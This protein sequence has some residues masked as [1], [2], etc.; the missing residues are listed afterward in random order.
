MAN[1]V[2]Q[3]SAPLTLQT[4]TASSLQNKFQHRLVYPIGLDKISAPGEQRSA[5]IPFAMFLPYYRAGLDT[6]VSTGPKTVLDKIP[7]PQF[8]IALPLPTS[9][10]RTGY[11]VTYDTVE[12]GEF[13]MIT[14]GVKSIINQVSETRSQR[15]LR[16]EKNETGVVVPE[17][18]IGDFISPTW[19]VIKKGVGTS[20]GVVALNVALGVAGSFHEGLGGA[21]NKTLGVQKNP[22]TEVLFKNVGFRTHT[23][24]YRFLPKSLEES[25]L[26]DQIIQTFRYYMLPAYLRLSSLGDVA[27]FFSFP[28]E[29][30]IVSSQSATT[31]SMLPSVLESLNVDYGGTADSPKFFV[32]DKR[33]QQYPTQITLE[34]TFKEIIILTRDI[35]TAETSSIEQ[36]QNNVSGLDTL[37]SMFGDAVR[38]PSAERY[39]F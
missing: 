4:L 34:L 7:A 18:G 11:A 8:C 28:Y 17:D 33:G 13:G 37:T 24:A 14:G 16:R 6:L 31:F 5:Q 32:A 26:I 10:L 22:F 36:D 38:V 25:K 15:Q 23:F 2:I 35:V 9:A 39:R 20:A 12:L 29:F 21:L 30:I 19:D 3:E 27:S 1:T